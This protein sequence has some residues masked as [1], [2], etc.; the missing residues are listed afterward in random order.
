[1]RVLLLC[2]IAAISQAADVRVR[3]FTVNPSTGPLGEVAVYDGQVD[4]V[5]L[6]PPEGWVIE[7]QVLDTSSG[8][9]PFRIVKAREVPG[10][11]Y[12]FKVNGQPQ[13]VSVASAPYGK[14]KI[15]GREEKMWA[16]GIPLSWKTN[17]KNTIL[18]MFWNEDTV[19]VA[20]EAE[21]ELKGAQLFFGARR[22]DGPEIRHELVLPVKGKCIL[23]DGSSAEATDAVEVDSRTRK[24]Q[25]ILEAAIP[26]EL[27]QGI[28][29]DAGREFYFSMLVHD[30]DGTV[31]DL[32][33]RMN[34][35]ESARKAGFWR[36]WSEADCSGKSVFD[37]WSGFGCCSSIH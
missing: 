15:D 4:Q 31:R 37:G 32:G 23:L 17:G 14:L 18:R 12:V 28:R 29:F 30:A 8:R 2:L 1:M 5:T 16:D 24:G 27:L 26:V 25:T 19:Y 7:P 21:G 20:I 11:A 9:A 13:T 35:P 33:E 34:R 6:T 22:K 10:N 36:V 3:N